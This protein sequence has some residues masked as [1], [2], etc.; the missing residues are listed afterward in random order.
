MFIFECQSPE[1][2]RRTTIETSLILQ[3]RWEQDTLIW[4]FYP[5]SCQQN[6]FYIIFKSVKLLFLKPFLF[7]ITVGCK[8][9]KCDQ[10]RKKEELIQMTEVIIVCW[11]C[12]WYFFLFSFHYFFFFFPDI[13]ISHQLR[14]QTPSPLFYNAE[15]P[16]LKWRHWICLGSSDLILLH[17]PIG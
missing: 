3:W 13:K 11:G 10:L 14:F 8:M 5:F 2:G 1:E 16:V 7:V 15:S 6:L 9:K 12:R 17:M 4:I